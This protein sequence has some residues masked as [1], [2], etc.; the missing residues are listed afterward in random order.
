[1]T[2]RF[3]PVQVATGSADQESQLVFHE[4][5]LVAILVR[6]SAEHGPDEGS[7]F[8]EAS[9]GQ[10]EVQRP[11]LFADLDVAQAWIMKNLND[12]S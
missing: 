8:L 9:F 1:M 5:F 11:P 4:G 12:P 2:L 7:W 3:Q 6:L 10:I